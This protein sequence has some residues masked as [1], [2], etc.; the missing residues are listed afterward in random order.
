VRVIRK[1]YFGLTRSSIR[2]IVPLGDMHVGALACDEAMIE[3][4][5]KDVVNDENA[6][7]I[8]MGDYTDSVN[9][10]DPRFDPSNLAPWIS[11]RD[12]TDIARVQRD[13]FLDIVRP[14]ALAG[15][16]LCLLEGNHETAI[17]HH[18][19]RDIYSEI[20]TT[21][22][23][24]QGMAEDEIL[25]LGYEGWLQMIF[26]RSE[27]REHTNIVTFNLHHGYG[28][29]RRPGGNV[30]RLADRMA[31]Y[32]AD[33]FLMGHTHKDDAHKE[34]VTSLDREG[35]IATRTKHG[36]YTGSFLRSFVGDSDTYSSRAGYAPLPIGNIEIM[37]RPGAEYPSKP[38]QILS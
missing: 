16:F 31:A 26:H 18:S 12:L 4:V 10:K 33:I 3:Q 13:R 8:G 11:V 21:I 37:L 6:Y 7:I 27:S 17:K 36:V 5:I 25:G 22:K 9:R 19:E 1:E 20:V 15:K 35:N 29:G 28:G 32:D 34:V 14:A 24:W 38:I 30:N 23:Q 2:R